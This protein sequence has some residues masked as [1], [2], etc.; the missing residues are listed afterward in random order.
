M[1]GEE[2]GLVDA[3]LIDEMEVPTNESHIEEVCED[4]AKEETLAPPPPRLEGTSDSTMLLQQLVALQTQTLQTL[5]SMQ[6]WPV[7][8][9]YRRAKEGSRQ[10]QNRQGTRRKSRGPKDF[11]MKCW[12]CSGTEQ[13]IRCCPYS[14]ASGR[15][16]C[17]ASKT[18]R[19]K[20]SFPKPTGILRPIPKCWN[21][22]DPGHKRHMCPQPRG[23]KC[24]TAH[25]PTH[26][27]C[28]NP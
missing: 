6:Q 2:G 13:R 3:K 5:Q 25:Y 20:Q 8:V 12:K 26:G 19:E 15:L 28:P 17:H 10:R 18:P 23:H 4:P 11:P 21:C 14:G 24:E 9:A 22:G 1:A 7:H 27:T 16:H